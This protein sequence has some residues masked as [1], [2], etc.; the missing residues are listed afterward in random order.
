MVVNNASNMIIDDTPLEE[1]FT[2]VSSPVLERIIQIIQKELEKRKRDGVPYKDPNQFVTH[3][4]R[5]VS[6]EDLEL[7]KW[8]VGGLAGKNNWLTNTGCP[9]GW[10][11]V[12]LAP[13]DITKYPNIDKLMGRINEEQGSEFN[14]CL[15]TRYRKG[16]GVGYHSDFE[17]SLVDES[18]ITVVSVG[19]DGAVDFIPYLGDARKRPRLSIST[20]DGDAY[21]MKP[22]CQE[23][24]KHRAR[25]VEHG[26]R[27][28]LS[29]RKRHTTSPPTPPTQKVPQFAVHR[30]PVAPTA[31]QMAFSPTSPPA[32]DGYQE[33]NSVFPTRSP[34]LPTPTLLN[35]RPAPRTLLLGTS[36]T[37]WVM[38]DP[39]L[40]NISVSGARLCRP[41]ENWRGSLAMDMLKGM[42][43][44]HPGLEVNKVILAFGTNDIRYWGGFVRSSKGKGSVYKAYVDI[45]REVRRRFGEDTEIVLATV[46]PLRPDSGWIASNV[47]MFNRIVMS[48]GSSLNC[49]VTD[50]TIGFLDYELN[51]NS[52]LFSEDGVHL[53]NNGYNVLNEI[54]YEELVLK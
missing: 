23:H 21:T 51:F 41:N 15:V 18:P 11:N 2:R 26:V 24:F 32:V 37:K 43:V 10:A 42:E 12:D 39:G 1:V 28:A 7:I 13:E 47:F 25:K 30:S 45:V 16:D 17:T 40:V 6:D 3:H 22:G 54:M 9:Y 53:N 5:Y 49:I 20:K 44:T 33:E 48:V 50:W 36:M 38:E 19:N 8:E 46:I 52:V 29:F 27:Y 34:L 35:S 14:S 31:S 4:G